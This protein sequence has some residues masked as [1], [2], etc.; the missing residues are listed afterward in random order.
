MTAND[1]SRERRRARIVWESLERASD[2]LTP[3]HPAE[4]Y[5]RY[6]LRAAEEYWISLS[7]AQDELL[8]KEVE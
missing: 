6:A 8:A 7:R 3:G 5:I 1:Q 4:L 2:H